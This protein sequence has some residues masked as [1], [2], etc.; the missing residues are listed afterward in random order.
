MQV[1]DQL[2]LVHRLEVRELRLV[3]GLDQRLERHLHQRRRPAAQHRLLAEQ[4]G[5]G[6]LREGRLEDAGTRRAERPGVGED[7]RAAVPVASR[8]T[9]NRAGTPPPA[10]YTLRT[11]VARAL[12][13]DH[14]DVDDGR[15]VDPP[16]V[17]VEA[18]REHQQL[19]GPEVRGD[20][21]VVDGLL[22]R[23][24]HEDHH[25]VRGLDRVRRRPPRE[26]GLLRQRTALGPGGQP[27]DHVHARLM[28]VERMGVA[29]AAVADDR[30]GLPGEGRR[31][32]VVVVVHRCRHRL[33]ASSM[34]PRAPGHD[35]GPG[36]DQLLDPVGAH[37][38]DERV[39]L[40]LA[41]GHL[42]DDRLRR[43]VDDPPLR[44]LHDLEHL[45]R[46]WSP[47]RAP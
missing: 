8:W 9:A 18:V 14:P 38:R 5:L 10:W 37:E 40:R 15:R 21:G 20:L 42:H 32:G 7:P 4:V 19:A 30:D 27:D 33:S 47:W 34:E 25:D 17:D 35:H 6:L 1:D 22:R 24:R 11:Q 43:Q 41:A 46:A 12:R 26:A 31:V 3:A 39:D 36:P 2:Q 16:E 45:G 28:Q 29:L 44:E 23:V 13:G